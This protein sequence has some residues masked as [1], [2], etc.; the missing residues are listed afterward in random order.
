MA[1]RGRIGFPMVWEASWDHQ[2]ETRSN[3]DCFHGGFPSPLPRGSHALHFSPWTTFDEP[4]GEDFGFQGLLFPFHRCVQV[5][6]VARVVIGRCCAWIVKR[7]REIINERERERDDDKDGEV[8]FLHWS[9][10]FF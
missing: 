6:E 1:A 4:P 9:I 2:H 3:T 10:Y 7:E 8:S 5:M